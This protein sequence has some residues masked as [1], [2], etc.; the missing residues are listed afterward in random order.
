MEGVDID[1]YG[2]SLTELS[3]G[4]KLYNVLYHNSASWWIWTH[5]K[6]TYL[7]VKLTNGKFDHLKTTV[8]P[9][10]VM[11]TYTIHNAR[12]V[13]AIYLEPPEIPVMHDLVFREV[14]PVC[15]PERIETELIRRPFRNKPCEIVCTYYQTES[16]LN[17]LAFT[18]TVPSSQFYVD[19][20]DAEELVGVPF[21]GFV[22]AIASYISW[23]LYLDGKRLRLELGNL[24]DYVISA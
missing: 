4:R 7:E 9:N 10:E 22:R 14:P 20:R 23:K 6:A 17:A 5:N 16:V 24:L 11:E 2:P 3:T 8:L 13:R 21:D 18:V 12:I 19:L 15:A 1:K